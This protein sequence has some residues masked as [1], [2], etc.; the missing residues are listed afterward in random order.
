MVVDPKQVEDKA[1]EKLLDRA[2]FLHSVMQ[3][4][5]MCMRASVPCKNLPGTMNSV[6]DSPLLARGTPSVKNPLCTIFGEEKRG[7]R[8]GVSFR[9]N[10]AG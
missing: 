3:M 1:L 10:T 4:R 8:K 9:E 5:L 2:R 6:L 7:S